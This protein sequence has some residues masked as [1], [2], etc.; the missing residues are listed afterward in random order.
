MPKFK[1]RVAVLCT[2]PHVID[3]QYAPRQV[4]R[5]RA[6]ALLAAGMATAETDDRGVVALIRMRPHHRLENVR[7]GSYGIL[8]EHVPPNLAAGL[9]GGIVY[10]HH[11]V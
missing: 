6:I 5:E 4:H 9:S 1:R 8:T 2:G 3:G 11:A 7:P 10:S